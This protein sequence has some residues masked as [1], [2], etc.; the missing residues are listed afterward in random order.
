MSHVT[1]FNG[2]VKKGWGYEYIFA[3]NDLY[4]GKLLHFTNKGNK[5]S[6]HFHSE[7]DESWYVTS[8]SFILRIL[9]SRDATVKEST[10]N[11]GDSIRIFPL[12][13]HQVEALEDDSELFEVSTA[14]SDEDNYRVFP[15]DNQ[16]A[17]D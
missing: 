12:T 8:G 11:K 4:C 7:K 9:D 6:M 5:F 2:F 1:R 3:T 14:D 13:I 17:R 10:L 16:I 15:G